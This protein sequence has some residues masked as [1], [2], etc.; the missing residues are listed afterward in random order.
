MK[1]KDIYARKDPTIFAI[2]LLSGKWR[3]PILRKIHYFEVIRYN[4]LKR[5]VSGITNTLLSQC[6]KELE[7]AHI[8]L[9]K[10][11]E[12][13]PMRVEYELTLEGKDLMERLD[14][15]YEWGDKLFRTYPEILEKKN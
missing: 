13:I 1:G 14:Q 2:K 10:Q 7:D 6:L 4:E 3:L 5:E 12:E 11:Y 15:I 9:R 8:I